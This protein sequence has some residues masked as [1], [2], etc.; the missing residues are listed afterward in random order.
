MHVSVNCEW[1]IMF[2][3]LTQ[4]LRVTASLKKF[5]LTRLETFK[6]FAELWLFMRND[7]DTWRS[8]Y[9]HELNYLELSSFIK[10]K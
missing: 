5:R 8:L 7:K 2:W 6:N 1:C 9:K 3:K 10:I 4:L